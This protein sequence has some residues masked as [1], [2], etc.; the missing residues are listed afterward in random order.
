[1]WFVVGGGC[2]RKCMPVVLRSFMPRFE[3]VLNVLI[4]SMVWSNF[5]SVL[6]R[7]RA[8]SAYCEVLIF[9]GIP[10][11]TIPGMEGSVLRNV[12]RVWATTT[13]KGRDSGQP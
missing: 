7:R 8:S 13:N 10:G 9:I 2:C 4:L 12:V 1:M 6:L 3:M 5:M 11:I